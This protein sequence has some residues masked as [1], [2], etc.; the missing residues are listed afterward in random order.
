MGKN[1]ALCYNSCMKFTKSKNGL[2]FFGIL[3][4]LCLTSCGNKPIPKSATFTLN[5]PTEKVKVHTDFQSEMIN[6]DNILQYVM[7]N[8]HLF[9]SEEKSYPLPAK[10][11]WTTENDTGRKADEYVIQVSE[12]EDFLSAYEYY[13]TSEAVDIIN[14]MPNTKYYWRVHARYK[15]TIFTSMDST[16]ETA[17]FSLRNIAAPLVIN[18]RD[19]GDNSHMK[20]GLIYRSGQ[21][22][23]DSNKYGALVSAPSEKGLWVLKQQLGIKT[24]IDLRKTLS[25]SFNYDEVVGITSSPLGEEVN[26]I[27]TPME[28]SNTNIFTND[29]NKEAIRNFFTALADE[30]NYPLVFH[31][32]RGTDRTGAL[33]YVLKALCG[34]TREELYLDYFFSNYSLIGTPVGELP[35]TS[36]SFYDHQINESEGTTLKDKTIN[37]LINNVGVSS[38]TLDKIIS[39]LAK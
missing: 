33:A 3:F 29:N 18:M 26:Y 5:G 22:N 4:S 15:T 1:N 21:F 34:C 12:T 9:G 38:T 32:V 16:F 24:E 11:Y 6:S 20:M 17:N 39:I 19:L 30:N 25:S 35:F 36:E 10:L 2:M 31:C 23:Y 27:S 7:D 8:N 14:L 13:S 37:Y 28:Y